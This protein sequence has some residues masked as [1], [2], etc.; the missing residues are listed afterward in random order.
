[1][2]KITF[3]ILVAISLVNVSMAQE[4]DSREKIHLGFKA[5]A[6][7]SN[8]YDVQGEKF[9]ADALIGLA[10][11]G[12]FKI[13]I[14]TFLGVQPEVLFSQKGYQG[15]G[16]VLGVDYSYS[17]RTN[18]IDIPLFIALNP[19]PNITIL[20]GPQYSYLIKQTDKFSSPIIDSEIVQDFENEKINKNIVCFVGGG[21]IIISNL[22]LG[23]RAGWDITKNNGDGTST[24]PRYKNAWYQATIG[25]VF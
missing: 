18:F 1:M 19:T 4:T 22:I 7:L 23:A 16:S 15:S 11:G 12:F 5:G 9:E 17:R 24:A 2:K 20:G 21:D 6:N 8:V 25:Y 13:P 3:I 10:V 14:G